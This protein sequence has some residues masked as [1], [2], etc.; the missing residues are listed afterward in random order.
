MEPFLQIQVK[1]TLFS[2]NG[3]RVLH[4]ENYINQGE[5]L[6]ISG[7]SG[8]GKTTLLRILAGLIHPDEGIIKCGN[9]IWYH[10]Q[11]KIFL[12][13]Q[14]RK[15]GLVFQDYALFPNMTVRRNLEFA[16]PKNFPVSSIHS[17]SQ[18]LGINHLYERKPNQLSGGEKQRVAFARALITKPDLLLLDEP[19]SSLNWELRWH[20]Q[21]ELKSWHQEFGC[22]T[23]VVSHDLLELFRLADRVL[24]LDGPPPSIEDLDKARNLIGELRDYLSLPP[25]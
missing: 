24:C 9:K 17:I 14:K 3:K 6:A 4:F 19:F 16:L 5:F 2:E 12:P 15:I 8:C 18:T 21:R 10:H 13:P 22:T 20:L 25:E 23:V 7:S 1:K 11:K